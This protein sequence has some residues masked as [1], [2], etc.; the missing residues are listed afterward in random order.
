M[1][2]RKRMIL[3]LVALFAVLLA[4]CGGGDS[5]SGGNGGDGGEENTPSPTQ[6]PAEDTE[7]SAQSEAG[8]ILTVTLADGWVGEGSEGVIRFANNQEALDL[9]E[10]AMLQAGQMQGEV[11]FLPD[12]GQRLADLGLT[13][14][15]V[16][17]DVLGTIIESLN[18]GAVSYE[19]S[20]PLPFIASGQV[21]AFATGTVAM[22]DTVLD[23]TV[24]IIDTRQ[25]FGVIKAFTPEDEIAQYEGRLRTL[26]GT[27]EYEPPAEAEE[28][29][30]EE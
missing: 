8:G 22:G 17:I 21:A 2:L 16:P 19:L 20:A 13:R 18:E 9:A 30:E 11:D 5:D 23:A 7:L 1:I 26:T 3:I 29:S 15:S 12:D 4:A 25:G 14:S 24:T 6:P 28:A 10:P 27:V